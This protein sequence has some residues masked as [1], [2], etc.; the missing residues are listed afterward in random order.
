[1]FFPNNRLYS[2]CP[3]KTDGNINLHNLLEELSNIYQYGKRIFSST[4]NIYLLLSVSPKEVFQTRL[5]KKNKKTKKKKKKSLTKRA[6]RYIYIYTHKHI[7]WIVFNKKTL[8]QIELS[9]LTK[10]PTLAQPLRIWFVSAAAGVAAEAWV[11]S[12]ALS[13]GLRIRVLRPLWHR[14]QL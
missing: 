14:S 3:R 5:T 11:Q 4:L 7:C 2:K 6:H 1:M 9:K 12:P 10:V 13:S 8:R